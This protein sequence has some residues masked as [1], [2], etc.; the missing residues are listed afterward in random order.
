MSAVLLGFYRLSLL[1]SLSPCSGDNSPKSLL[2]SASPPH[3]PTATPPAPFSTGTSS[4]TARTFASSLTSHRGRCYPVTK[5]EDSGLRHSLTLIS[6]LQRGSYSF[7]TGE[8]P[9]AHHLPSSR[10][11]ELQTRVGIR[12]ETSTLLV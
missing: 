11:R 4:T 12:L 7:G 3:N 6:M 8:M 10:S 2:S 5:E 1:C 9:Q